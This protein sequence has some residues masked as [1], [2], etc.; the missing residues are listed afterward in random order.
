M[1]PEEAAQK[2]DQAV[3]FADAMNKAAGDHGRAGDHGSPMEATV[4][5]A[6]LLGSMIAAL[7]VVPNGRPHI[8][9]HLVGLVGEY[10]L[11][12]PDTETMQ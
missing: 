1:T 7:D 3:A 9:R 12:Q 5:C 2:H 8:L 4:G 11:S 6:M 10:A